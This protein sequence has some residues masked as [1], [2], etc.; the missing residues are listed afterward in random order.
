MSGRR[1]A[2][3]VSRSTAVLLARAGV[4][5][6]PGISALPMI[7]GQRAADLPDRTLT[8]DEVRIDRDRLAAYD[9]VCGFTLRDRVP[10]T[11]PHVLA[12]P[13]HLQLITDPR[14]PL[15]PLGLVHVGNRIVQHRPLD[16]RE[17]LVISVRAAD[18]RPHRR[19]RQFDLVTEARV[20]REL[21]WE[22]TSTNLRVERPAESGEARHAERAEESLPAVARWRVPG[23]A[24]R[25]YA[26]VSGDYN[27]IHLH[28]FSARLLGFRAANAHGMWTH[29]RCLAAL[30][31]LL[32]DGYGV[33]V[34]FKRPLV[35]PATVELGERRDAATGA[36]GFAVRDAVDGTPH[37]DGLLEP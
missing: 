6:L 16:V 20:D 2:T 29:A 32:P 10:A 21:V 14:F 1:R 12:F 5:A 9:R 3:I 13:L 27:P 33:E 30:E 25:R 36:I 19:G 34:A 37:L 7:G 26:A 28:R 31:P 17:P 23:D 22:G 24:G 8:L 11:Y 35:L 18:L 15:P 4:Q